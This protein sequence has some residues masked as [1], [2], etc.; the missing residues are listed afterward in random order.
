LFELLEFAEWA[1]WVAGFW[2]FIF[3]PRFRSAAISQW[4]GRK[5]LEHLLTVWEVA[6][7][8]ACAA[9][10]VWVI[11]ALSGVCATSRVAAA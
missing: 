3:S 1:W 10:T 7:S 11:L 4:R 6:L 2:L 8:T 9:I 5:G